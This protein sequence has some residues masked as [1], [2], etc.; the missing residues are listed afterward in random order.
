MT[1]ATKRKGR[2]ATENLRTAKWHRH[3]NRYDRQTPQGL[4]V[5]LAASI[6]LLHPHLQ[7]TPHSIIGHRV[8]SE[9]NDDRP[10]QR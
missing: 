2:A 5:P 4:E 10:T 1:T 6:A 3:A 7:E 9:T 8:Q